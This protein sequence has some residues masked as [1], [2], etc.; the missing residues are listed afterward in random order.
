MSVGIKEVKNNIFEIDEKDL[1]NLKSDIPLSYLP[2]T[3][4]S[5]FITS[6]PVT[7][8]ENFGVSL[9]DILMLCEIYRKNQK[10]YMSILP[11]CIVDF[12]EK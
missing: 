5:N 9:D 2:K 11:D 1:I 4:K 6:V 12:S 3:N 10:L 7:K 8:L